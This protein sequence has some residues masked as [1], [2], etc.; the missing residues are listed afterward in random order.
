MVDYQHT[1]FKSRLHMSLSSDTHQRQYCHQ[2]HM[3]AH[4]VRK[5]SILAA[6]PGTESARPQNLITAHRGTDTIVFAGEIVV[7]GIPQLGSSSN[8]RAVHLELGVVAPQLTLLI[9]QGVV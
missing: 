8:L 5:N 7:D 1:T 9:V 4:L 3:A 6:L 2:K